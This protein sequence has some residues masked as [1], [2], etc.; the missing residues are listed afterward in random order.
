MMKFRKIISD[1]G[2]LSCLH[3]LLLLPPKKNSILGNK[4]EE[5]SISYWNN[6]DKKIHEINVKLDTKREH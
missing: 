4:E 1:F 5:K 6:R 3:P 2:V